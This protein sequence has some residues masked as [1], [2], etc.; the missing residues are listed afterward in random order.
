MNCHSYTLQE[1][2]NLD[3]I[4]NKNNK[5]HN[6]KWPYIPDKPYRVLITGGFG[7]EKTNALLN[8]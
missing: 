7:S 3:D 1:M 4:T 6:S 5:D 8:Y 2:F